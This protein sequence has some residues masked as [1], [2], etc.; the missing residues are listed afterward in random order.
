MFQSRTLVGLD[1]KLSNVKRGEQGTCS[2]EI[3]VEG[4]RSFSLGIRAQDLCPFQH[5]CYSQRL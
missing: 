5:L 1:R 3:W 4:A 2:P